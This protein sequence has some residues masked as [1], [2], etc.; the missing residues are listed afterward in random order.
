[1]LFGADAPEGLKTHAALTDQSDAWAV[2]QLK[3]DMAEAVLARLVPVDL[4]QSH[5]KRGHALRTQLNHM[6][7]HI[8]RLGNTSFRLMCFRSMAKTMVHELSEA[9]GAVRARG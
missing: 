7:V 2:V 4:R 6:N 5:V 8:T 1:M 9:M 3:G